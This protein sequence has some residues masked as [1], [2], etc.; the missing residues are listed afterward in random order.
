MRKSTFAKKVAAR[1]ATK[2]ST[3]LQV[4][5]AAMTEI[6]ETLTTGERVKLRGLGSFGVKL[7]L[8]MKPENGMFFTPHFKPARSFK[9]KITDEYSKNKVEINSTKQPTANN[10][11][12]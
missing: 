5:E 8:R 12:H 11:H 1:T 4:L 6:K 2:K 3:V 7:K 10:N 9:Q